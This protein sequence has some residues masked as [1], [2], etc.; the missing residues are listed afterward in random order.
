MD[1]RATVGHHRKLVLEEYATANDHGDFYRTCQLQLKLHVREEAEG[2]Q[3]RG[4]VSWRAR[5]VYCIHVLD[6]VYVRN[7]SAQSQLF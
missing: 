1:V 7:A 6:G 4:D 3:R 2:E 5:T